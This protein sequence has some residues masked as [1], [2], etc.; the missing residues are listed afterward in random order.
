VILHLD[1]PKEMALR[2]NAYLLDGGRKKE[3]NSKKK[4]KKK[5]NFEDD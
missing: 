4:K 5:K 1:A 3:L 2:K